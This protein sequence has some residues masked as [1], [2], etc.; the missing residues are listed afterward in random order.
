MMT[1]GRTIVG[2]VM[3]FLCPALPAMSHPHV[4]A[5]GHVV[6]VVDAARE[7]TAVK[8][9]WTFDAPFSAYAVTG[10]DKNHDGKLD[11]VELRPLAETSMKSLA[12]YH[13]FTWV[14]SK[15]A[16]IE[17]SQPRDY[18]Y[19]FTGGRLILSFTMPLK[20]PAPVTDDLKIEIYDPEYFVA[21]SFPDRGAAEV[22]GGPA[23]CRAT[24]VPPK[25]LDAQIMSALAA[26]PAEQHDL[27]PALLD[28]AVGLA[29]IFLV[30]CP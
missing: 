13:F 7:L 27:P 1:K 11:A 8:N 18:A 5:D 2:A 28:A 16:E 29:N 30:K 19:R 21:Y 22:K 23:D 15:G 17:L 12:D 6:L 3:C 14:T 26:I 9:E 4:F 24:F 20:A 25:P 10:L